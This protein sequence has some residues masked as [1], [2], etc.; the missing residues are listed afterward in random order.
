MITIMILLLLL[1]IIIIIV[2]MIIQPNNFSKFPQTSEFSEFPQNFFQNFCKTSSFRNFRK[3]SAS[4]AR[5]NGRLLAHR[6]PWQNEWSQQWLKIP[7]LAGRQRIEHPA[8]FQISF[9]LGGWSCQS[10]PRGPVSVSVN[11]RLP[12]GEPLP[13]SPA[14][15]DSF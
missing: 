3:T 5:E 6:S 10:M 11:K 8:G 13:C 1:L 12:L 4:T 2:I 15:D 7:R 9:H 14:A